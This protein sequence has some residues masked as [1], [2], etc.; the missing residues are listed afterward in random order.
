MNFIT[1]SLKKLFLNKNRAVHI[2]EKIENSKKKKIW[3]S[4]IKF[5]FYFIRFIHI[6]SEIP[7]S[8]IIENS[9]GVIVLSIF[10]F[11]RVG[12]I[13]MISICSTIFA[14]VSV[15]CIGN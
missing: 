4:I 13:V 9:I 2:P 14:N 7:D 5:F 8:D 6:N 12:V 11:I 3:V 15:N 10:K 1:F